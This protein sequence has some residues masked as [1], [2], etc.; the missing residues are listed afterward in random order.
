[1]HPHPDDRPHNPD[2]AAQDALTALGHPSTSNPAQHLRHVASQAATAA[3]STPA[4]LDPDG[5]L[6]RAV[7]GRQALAAVE[8]LERTVT[9]L[10]PLAEHQ[11]D[12]L[13]Q[14]AL[15]DAFDL[16]GPPPTAAPG[17]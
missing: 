15:A 12:T 1:M 8:T 4:H 13:E 10:A 16:P 11:L 6:P 3:R 2:K 7:T 14:Q 17:P 5:R 9:A